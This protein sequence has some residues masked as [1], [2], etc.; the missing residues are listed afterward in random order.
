M[1]YRET[2]EIPP[3]WKD[4]ELDGFVAAGLFRFEIYLH[5]HLL[6]EIYWELREFGNPATLEM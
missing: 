5:N 1:R 2:E 6:F 4:L 3:A